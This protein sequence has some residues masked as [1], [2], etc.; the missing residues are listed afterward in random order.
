VL[1]CAGVIV[2]KMSAPTSLARIGLAA[3]LGL[4]AAGRADR[5][6]WSLADDLS[7][8]SRGYVSNNGV[9]TIAPWPE[10]SLTF[11][12]GYNHT[13]TPSED[14]TRSVDV[15]GSV[16]VSPRISLSLTYSL[17]NGDRADVYVMPAV[18]ANAPLSQRLNPE[19]DVVGQADERQL[20][21]TFGG[22]VGIKVVAP[23]DEDEEPSPWRPAVR[24]DLG[25]TDETQTLPLYEQQPLG[26]EW[27]RIGYERN[28]DRAYVSGLSVDVRS[29]TLGCTYTRH[30]YTGATLLTG[31]PTGQEAF[32][33]AQVLK[34]LH[35]STSS[36][37]EG[38]SQ[39][40]LLLSVFQR[41]PWNLQASLAYTYTRLAPP[42]DDPAA[43]SLARTTAV[44]LAWSG[45]PWMEARVGASWL[46]QYGATT[47]YTT[48]GASVFY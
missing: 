4:A 19:V 8:G 11:G 31:S 48:A 17:F 6:P 46:L 42:G 10:A 37:L 30:H 45:L 43:T 25:A 14:S 32:V 2:I 16:E 35:T 5:A 47:T 44:T 3:A 39:H 34:D 22:V 9:A 12:A 13:T 20:V 1:Q 24:L 26:K 36:P 41:L 27:V 23:S 28:A 7:V 18:P 33:V 15:G 21:R 29:T 40:D 38:L